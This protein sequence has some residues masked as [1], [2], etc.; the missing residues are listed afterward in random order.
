MNLLYSA[1]A[2]CLVSFVGNY[3]KHAGFFSLISSYIWAQQSALLQNG[4]FFL[5]RKNLNTRGLNTF[6]N[7]F[8]STLEGHPHRRTQP[9][10]AQLEIRITDS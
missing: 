2:F 6:Q 5:I 4:A 7:I 8:Q 3:A 9:R 1:F 10:K